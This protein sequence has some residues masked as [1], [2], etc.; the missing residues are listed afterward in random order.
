MK[1][2]T[3]LSLAGLGLSE[4]DRHEAAMWMG[5]RRACRFVY[6]GQGKGTKLRLPLATLGVSVLQHMR[7]PLT[8]L[9]LSS[10]SQDP[11]WLKGLQ[12]PSPSNGLCLV[13]SFDFCADAMCIF[14]CLEIHLLCLR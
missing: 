7:W 12:L 5:G 3:V 13:A 14:A 11:G 10:F 6:N 9:P 8:A 4:L 2:F 1:S